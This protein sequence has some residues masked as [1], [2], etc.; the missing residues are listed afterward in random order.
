MDNLAK[1]ASLKGDMWC[2]HEHPRSFALE[3]TVGPAR[4]RVGVQRD[5]LEPVDL[6]LPLLR[7]PLLLLYV[8]HTPRGGSP[9]G[10]YQSGP[11]T[12]KAVAS[13]LE[14]HRSYLT[15]DGRHDL[16][17]AS[18]EGSQLVWDRHDL[19]YA[20]G[21]LE[22]FEATLLSVGYQ[23]GPVDVPS[24]HRHSYHS[25]FDGEEEALLA[26]R[27]GEAPIFKTCRRAVSGAKEV[28]RKKCRA[29]RV[30]LLWHFFA[31]RTVTLPAALLS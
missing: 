23:P 18:R 12:Q 22:R 31:H 25:E 21:P 30:A 6:L 11:L 20:Y 24:P 19:L 15:R 10:R 4:L 1:L 29:N 28:P 27:L 16:W 2:P 5:S 8:L 26:E 17:I 7:E 14:S 9:S 3:K 13:F